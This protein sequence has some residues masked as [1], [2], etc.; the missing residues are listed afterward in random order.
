MFVPAWLIVVYFQAPL[1]RFTLATVETADESHEVIRIY[2]KKGQI[3]FKD[4]LHDFGYPKW[5]PDGKSLAWLEDTMHV[6]VWNLPR[7][8]KRFR[9]KNPFTDDYGEPPGYE[10]YPKWSPDGKHLLLKIPSVQGEFDLHTGALLCVSLETKKSTTISKAACDV[11]WLNARTVRY[12]NLIY[13]ELPQ[14]PTI[15]WHVWRVRE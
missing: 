4:R 9:I 5:S 11:E 3:V 14:P 8:E 2:D 6:C 12:C 15:R 7:G 13:N 1:Y 10:N